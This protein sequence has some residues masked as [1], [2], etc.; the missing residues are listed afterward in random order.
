[1]KI[2]LFAANAVVAVVVVAVDVLAVAAANAETV[3][4]ELITNKLVNNVNIIDRYFFYD[5]A[6][7]N[8]LPPPN[9]LLHIFEN[10]FM[11]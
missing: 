6:P 9:P 5:E 8:D 10:D 3:L 7:V 2:G 4:V 11:N 1:M